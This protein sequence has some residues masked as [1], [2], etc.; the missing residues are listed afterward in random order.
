MAVLDSSGGLAPPRNPRLLA[1]GTPFDRVMN[2]ALR[3]D[4]PAA[5]QIGDVFSPQGTA[6]LLAWL[7]APVGGGIDE[8]VNRY[9]AKVYAMRSDLRLAFP[10]LAGS[11]ARR[12]IDWAWGPGRVEL[13]LAAKLLPAP[14]PW[15]R[16]RFRVVRLCD[17]AIG[18]AR[19]I[20]WRAGEAAD[21]ITRERRAGAVARRVER[22]RMASMRAWTGYRAR[23][24]GGVVT[25]IRSQEFRTQHLLDLWQ[26]MDIASVVE[27]EVLGSHPSML[28]EPDVGSLAA[29]IGELVDQTLD[30]PDRAP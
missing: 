27:R 22:V 25:V 15:S 2:H 16:V 20:A 11:D 3:S 13:G 12:L 26:G 24:Y 17:Q 29:C 4:G 5:A 7:A 10:D 18:L 1:D 6:R 30:G 28:R 19:R 9:L 23:S 21:L 8:T 14:S